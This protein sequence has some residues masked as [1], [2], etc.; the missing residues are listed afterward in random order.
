MKLAN[1]N[2]V[3]RIGQIIDYLRNNE[4]AFTCTEKSIILSNL[5]NDGTVYNIPNICLQIYDELGI[6]PDRINSYKAFADLV[7][8]QFSI[9]NKNIVEIGG[10][11]IPRLGKR[12]AAMQ[13]EGTI[14]VY[15]PNL[16]IVEGE[17]RSNLKLIKRSFNSLINVSKY[18]LLIGLLPCGSSSTIIK[19]AV[20][21]NR[22]FMIALCDSC[23][24]YE[25]F[26]NYEEDPNWPYNFIEETK[27]IVEEN[28]LGKVKV[29]Y[30][31]EVGD[32]YPII[33]NDRG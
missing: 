32:N 24:F 31:K 8:E 1:N 16:H 29:K 12:I 7:D 25:Y 33:Y 22:D 5:N 23:S 9:K 28:N 3:Q 10:G 11:T 18:D 21:Y 2:D 20:R 14:T 19:S 17:E 4:D 13:D 6:L 27:K 30:L 15:D 26:D